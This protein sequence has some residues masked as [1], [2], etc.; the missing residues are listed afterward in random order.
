MNNKN[1]NSPNRT[2]TY[3]DRVKAL[4]W[5]LKGDG[6]SK[7]PDLNYRSC[8]DE[9][10]IHYRTG[11]TID[12][13][14]ITRKEADSRFLVCMQKKGMVPILGTHI[15]PFFYWAAVRLFGETAWDRDMGFYEPPNSE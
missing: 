5:A 8:C 7:V 15:V 6:C 10:D 14:K 4:A 2:M 12:G 11:M 9:H 13:V 1:G 3:W